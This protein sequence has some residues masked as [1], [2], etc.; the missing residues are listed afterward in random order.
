MWTWQ[1]EPE[2]APVEMMGLGWN[3][4]H[5]SGVG[6][7]AITSGI[8]GPWTTNPTQWDMGY[9]ELLLNTNGNLKKSPAG[10]TMA[11]NGLC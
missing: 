7:D 4:K 2:G 11:S 5:A 8:E 1:A 3:N 9:L 10:L 6:V